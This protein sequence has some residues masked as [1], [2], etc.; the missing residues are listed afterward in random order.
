MNPRLYH[1]AGRVAAA[2]ELIPDAVRHYEMVL[3]LAPND[4]DAVMALV[5]LWIDRH[6]FER[7]QDL[8]ARKLE[9]GAHRSELYLLLGM[10]YREA[11]AW[12]E[13]LRAFE[14]ASAAASTSPQ[15]HFL[16]GAQL[17]RLHQEAAA[18]DELRRAIALDPRHADALNYLGYMDAEDG[19]NLDEA[20]V[21]IQ[22]ALEVEPDNGAYLDSL[23]WVYFRMGDMTNALAQLR[24]AAELVDTDPTIFEH[25]GDVYLAHGDVDNARKAWGRALELDHDLEPIK[26]KLRQLPMTPLLIPAAR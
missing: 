2:L 26:Q 19:V 12:M 11:G 9:S 6:Q 8:L 17:E 15:P 23:G 21:L 14:G 18:R 7:V 1:H 24:R 25:L 4:L 3:E 13:A 16:I 5:R 20:K 10:F 22:R